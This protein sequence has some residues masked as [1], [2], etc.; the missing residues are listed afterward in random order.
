VI[1][2]TVIGGTSLSGGEGT[3]L[4]AFLGAVIMGVLRNGMILLGVSSFWQQVVIG[5]VIIIAIAIDQIR[6][7]KER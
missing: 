6:R 5:I 3:I 2:A 7:A 4:G 1:A